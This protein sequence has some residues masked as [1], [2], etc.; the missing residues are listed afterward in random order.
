MKQH[1]ASIATAVGLACVAAVATTAANGQTIRPDVDNAPSI[2]DLAAAPA[3]T[4]SRQETRREPGYVGTV[5]ALLDRAKRYPTGREASL[6]RPSGTAEVWFVLSRNGEVRSLGLQRSSGSMLLDTMAR[7]LVHR[8]AYPA[9]P[10]DAWQGEEAHRFAV[11]YAFGEQQRVS[12]Q[13]LDPQ[14]A[15]R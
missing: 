2:A 7:S 5:Y 9:F 12:V 3:A 4:E 15:E 11:R 1:L 6:T 14:M 13:R 8:A 10:G